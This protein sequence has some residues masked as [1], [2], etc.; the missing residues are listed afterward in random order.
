[1]EERFRNISTSRSWS[2]SEREGETSLGRNEIRQVGAGG[3]AG[4]KWGEGM[5]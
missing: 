5:G 3:C 4:M 2:R 1:M